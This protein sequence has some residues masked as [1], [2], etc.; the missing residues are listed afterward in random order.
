M[1]P[2]YLPKRAA[3]EYVGLSQ[4][5]LDYARSRGDLPFYKIGPRK[6]VFRVADLDKYMTRFRVDVGEVVV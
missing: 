5:T 1:S 6:V 3:A 4:R 2:G